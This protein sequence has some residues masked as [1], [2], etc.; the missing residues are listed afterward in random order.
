M[1]SFFEPLMKFLKLEK[2][3]TD[4][5]VFRLH[6]K[7]TLPMFIL[8]SAM[9]TAKQ[10]FG[11][12]ID[13]FV[14]GVPTGIVNTYCWTHGTY[15]VK[16]LEHITRRP[17]TE[18]EK[19]HLETFYHDGQI[20]PGIRTSD[21]SVNKR[22]YYVFY[23]WVCFVIFIQA[24]FFF[25]PRFIWKQ[26]VEGGK[27]KFLTSGMK[28]MTTSQ[29]AVRGRLDRLHTG[30]RKVRGRNDRYAYTFCILE[31]LNLANVFL[32]F[33]ITDKFLHGKFLDYG[34]RLLEYHKYYDVAWDPMDEVFPKIAKCQF[35]RHGP[36][37]GIQNHDALCLLPLNIVNEKIYL[38]MWIWLIVLGVASGLAVLYRLVC[39]SVPEVRV[40]VLWKSFNKWSDVA[41]VCKKRP[42]GDWFLLRQMAKNVEPDV[43]DEFLKE[44]SE[45]DDFKKHKVP[46]EFVSTYA[47]TSTLPWNLGSFPWKNPNSRKTSLY[48]GTHEMDDKYGVSAPVHSAGTGDVEN[49]AIN[50]NNNKINE[51]N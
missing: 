16:A 47:D 26:F 38:F 9:L 15:T 5:L 21:P 4:N 22:Q 44:L 48:P 39:I 3:E 17:P 6:Y 37:G 43:F 50:H 11:D 27:M 13:C 49:G 1:Q 31:V 23:Q 10:Y 42:Y 2:I 41:K 40:L 29:E 51:N 7:V 34:S 14:Q 19:R 30:F 36:G 12:P 33:I 18:D 20:H 28:D 45:N 24:I 25:I 32:Q 35:N 46:E 8:F